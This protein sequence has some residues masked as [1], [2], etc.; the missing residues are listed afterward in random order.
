MRYA[1]TASCR[2]SGAEADD[3]PNDEAPGALINVN[4]APRLPSS[5]CPQPRSVD[6]S[7][8]FAGFLH[9]VL[10]ALNQFP[11]CS[12]AFQDRALE[13]PGTANPPTSRTRR[14]TAQSHLDGGGDTEQDRRIKTPLPPSKREKSGNDLEQAER[15]VQAL[16]AQQQ[17]PRPSI[18]NKG[19]PPEQ[20]ECPA[21]SGPAP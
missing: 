15:R 18:G 21:W 6:R 3:M 11:R 17:R 16:E 20:I 10:L 9:G 4:S 8:H 7:R 5:A 12:R 1:D 14:A 2:A 13:A 19:Q